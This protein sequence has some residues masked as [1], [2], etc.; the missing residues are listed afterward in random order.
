MPT[1]VARY[2][3]VENNIVSGNLIVQTILS[4]MKRAAGRRHDGP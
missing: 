1:N 4:F 2:N 3:T